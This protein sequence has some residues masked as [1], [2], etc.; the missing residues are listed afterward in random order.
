MK[1]ALLLLLIVQVA[2]LAPNFGQKRDKKAERAAREQAELAQIRVAV[3]SN[4]FN[5]D[6]D[7]LVSAPRLPMGNIQLKSNYF[8]TITP[9]TLKCYLPIY[10]SSKAYSGPELTSRLE[11][12]LTDGEFEVKREAQ[13]KGGWTVTI[14]TTRKIGVN[15]YT[16]ILNIPESGRSV[17]MSVANDYSGAARF[18]GDIYAN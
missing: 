17:S 3:E 2:I 9:K 5:F 11:F 12:F 10:G 1:K 8:L 18:S 6:A 13:K 15:T 4:N 14:R 7:V 16:F